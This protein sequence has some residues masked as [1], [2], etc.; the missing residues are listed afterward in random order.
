MD[1]RCGNSVACLIRTNEI[2]RHASPRC[3]CLELPSCCQHVA[4][5]ALS[6]PVA[7]A[8]SRSRASASRPAACKPSSARGAYC[9]TC[10]I[11]SH[12]AQRHEPHSSPQ[13]TLS[14]AR[15]ERACWCSSCGRDPTP[16]TPRH[17]GARCS[18]RTAHHAPPPHHTP[19]P[20]HAPPPTTH[21]RPPRTTA[22][23][24]TTAHHAPR[25]STRTSCISR[26]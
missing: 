24:R 25:R 18:P 3:R 20:H 10:A 1:R 2:H 22:A 26:G 5:A 16:P 4:A 8:R 12:A 21:H 13:Q 14:H 11:P 17:S 7:L 23:P 15:D 19:P 9:A 6:C